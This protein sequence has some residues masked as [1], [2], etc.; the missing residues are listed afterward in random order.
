MI[1][2]PAR[3]TDTAYDARM[4]A[5]AANAAVTWG[6]EYSPALAVD[7][8][9]DQ[10]ANMGVFGDSYW[11]GPRGDERWALLAAHCD[12]YDRAP[13]TRTRTGQLYT[14]GRGKQVA[15][16]NY[17][18]RPASLARDWWLDRGL[19]SVADPLGWYEWFWWYWLGRR[20]E[21]YDGWQIARWLNFKERH[22]AMLR[23]AP[24]PGHAQALLQWGIAIPKDVDLKPVS[25]DNGKVINGGLF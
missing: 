15:T 21:L 7:Y 20:I 13:P 9:P 11:G 17:Y 10:M 23:S 5:L 6:G 22:T 12:Y 1:W 4:T 19:I 16:V 3:P 14:N 8:T 25:G 24:F 18:G 2:H